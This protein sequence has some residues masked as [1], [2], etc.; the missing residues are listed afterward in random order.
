[1][2]MKSKDILKQKF[3]MDR[4]LN[5]YPACYKSLLWELLEMHLK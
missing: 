1:M 5:S 2:Q 3:T 4:L